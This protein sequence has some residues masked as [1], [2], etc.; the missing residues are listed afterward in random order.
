MN[1]HR[2]R[3]ISAR[4]LRIEEKIRPVEERKI[5]PAPCSR[6]VERHCELIER[7]AY[8]ARARDV[9]APRVV[10]R[11]VPQNWRRAVGHLEIHHVSREVDDLV[12]PWCP[13]RQGQRNIAGARGIERHRDPDRATECRGRIVGD[14]VANVGNGN[15]SLSARSARELRSGEERDGG[16]CVRSHAGTLLGVKGRCYIRAAFDTMCSHPAAPEG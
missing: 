11:F 15:R 6:I 12:G 5:G 14:V 9:N 3:E 10:V 2:R 13:C 7:H 4:I 16:D 8:L 1:S